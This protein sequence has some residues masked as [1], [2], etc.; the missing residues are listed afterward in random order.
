LTVVLPKAAT[1]LKIATAVIG[2]ATGIKIKIRDDLD[3]VTS[4]RHL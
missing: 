4:M 2:L 3:G 1:V